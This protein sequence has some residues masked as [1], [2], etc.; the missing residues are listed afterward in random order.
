MLHEAGSA[1]SHAGASTTPEEEEV[2]DK[3]IDE[4]RS[5]RSGS[6]SRRSRCRARRSRSPCVQEALTETQ[7]KIQLIT[8]K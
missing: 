3:G 8:T 4:G 6:W 7:R 2:S 5:S 1:V